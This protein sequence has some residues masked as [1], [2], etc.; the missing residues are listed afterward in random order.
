MKYLTA[1]PV[2]NRV[3]TFGIRDS[4]F[5]LSNIED[6]TDREWPTIPFDIKNLEDYPPISS[7]ARNR[8][9]LVSDESGSNKWI[10][11]QTRHQTLLVDAPWRDVM[12]WLRI[13][14]VDLGEGNFYVKH[15][16][17][18]YHMGLGNFYL[19]PEL[20]PLNLPLI[21][22]PET[23]TIQEML[24]TITEVFNVNEIAEHLPMGKVGRF[25]KGILV[26]GPHLWWFDKRGNLAYYLNEYFFE[27]AISFKKYLE[28]GETDYGIFQL[29]REN[30]GNWESPKLTPAMINGLMTD[31]VEILSATGTRIVTKTKADRYTG[32]EYTIAGYGRFGR[33]D[34]PDRA[35]AMIRARLG[36][37]LGLEIRGDRF[38]GLYNISDIKGLYI[39]ENASWVEPVV[40]SP[41]VD[42]V[43]IVEEVKEL[44]PEPPAL[45]LVDEAPANPLLQFHSNYKQGWQLGTPTGEMV[46][47]TANQ[48]EG[49][50]QL[51]LTPQPIVQENP[52]ADGGCPLTACTGTEFF[53]TLSEDAARILSIKACSDAISNPENHAEITNLIADLKIEAPE[54]V[55]WD[56]SAAPVKESF[57]N[58][59]GDFVS[60]VDE[61][62]VEMMLGDTPIICSGHI[63]NHAE[64]I[65]RKMVLGTIYL[66]DVGGVYGDL[67]PWT[68]EPYLNG[69]S[70][71]QE[72]M[73]DGEYFSNATHTIIQLAGNIYVAKMHVNIN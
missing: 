44:M 39:R 37:C 35:V 9:F 53:N 46:V 66:I 72:T 63:S 12:I 16:T 28:Q 8:L 26:T 69:M 50:T 17:T 73:V 29:P 2:Y 59:A 47:E 45:I 23:L 52:L 67:I 54:K 36:N 1:I 48:P 27:G 41:M 10:A 25:H 65:P 33:V 57:F 32:G 34:L 22:R 15:M 51:E 38:I 60:R 64:I 7:N 6:R 3:Y 42:V 19:Y 55:T 18:N 40:K 43:D 5:L 58:V 21:R 14:I 71:I 61:T 62:I 24:S 56:I 4:K 13:N 31:N 30:N 68:I 11:I 49:N 70:K 20:N